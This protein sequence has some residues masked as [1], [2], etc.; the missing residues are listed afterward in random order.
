MQILGRALKQ[1]V[2]ESFDTLSVDQRNAVYDHVYDLAHR[3]PG[4]E[5]V[6]FDSPQWGEEHAREHILRFIDALMRQQI[7]S[8][9]FLR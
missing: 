7:Q 4:A 3:E 5:N 6:N 2:R 8:N 1:Y 9:T